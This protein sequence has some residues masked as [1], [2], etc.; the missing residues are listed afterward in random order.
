MLTVADAAIRL[1]RSPETV[2]RWIVTGRLPATTDADGRL[3]VTA[4]D[5]DALRDTLYPTLELPK[6]WQRFEDGTPVPNW[7]AAV[8]L[9]RRGPQG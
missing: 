2:R 4:S 9:T 1:G 6:E 7:V 5:V 8:A 3:A